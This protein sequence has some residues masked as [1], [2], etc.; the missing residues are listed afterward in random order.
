M[1]TAISI[2]DAIYQA[3]DEMAARLGLSRSQLYAKAVASFVERHRRPAVTEQLNAVHGQAES[4]L[5]P[6]LARMQFS[7][8]PKE[9]W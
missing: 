9:E 3:A 2:P 4:R 7:S 8:L 5:D 1:R 6:V